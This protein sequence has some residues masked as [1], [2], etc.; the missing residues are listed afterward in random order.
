MIYQP[1]QAPIYGQ[2]S[3][4]VP[5]TKTAAVAP[6]WRKTKQERVDGKIEQMLETYKLMDELQRRKDEI[7]PEKHRAYLAQKYF[8][9]NEGG[10]AE[11]D[12]M[13]GVIQD[14]DEEGDGMTESVYESRHSSNM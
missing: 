10:E 4:K 11:E 3:E 8:P 2:V 14:D 6:V 7:G 1:N 13:D 12:D 5:S 9:D